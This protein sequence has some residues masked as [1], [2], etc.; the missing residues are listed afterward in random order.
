MLDV[1][2][3]AFLRRGEVERRFGDVDEDLWKLWFVF[4]SGISEQID[5][6]RR[7]ERA[8]PEEVGQGCAN[9]RSLGWTK[10]QPTIREERRNLTLSCN[11]W[12]QWSRGRG[13]MKAQLLSSL[14]DIHGFH[15]VDQHSVA[16]SQPEDTARALLSCF[17]RSPNTFRLT[18][19]VIAGCD[20]SGA[21]KRIG[22][23]E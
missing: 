3:E 21:A 18:L 6:E 17:Q 7:E 2:E 8:G 19:P 22:E 13:K 5:D 16:R 15:G 12:I 14:R 10:D 11:R 1:V 20:G 9:A 23:R 4:A